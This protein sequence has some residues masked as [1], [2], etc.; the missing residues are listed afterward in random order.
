MAPRGS[1]EDASLQPRLCA[2]ASCVS[3]LASPEPP[4]ARLA[5]QPR[6][7]WLGGGVRGDCVVGEIEHIIGKYCDPPSA[8]PRPAGDW[9]S[10]ERLRQID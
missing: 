8:R 5:F 2:S 6:I 3:A 1:V 7:D 9:P 4:W 10:E